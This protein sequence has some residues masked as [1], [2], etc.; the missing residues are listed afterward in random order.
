MRALFVARSLS[1]T[2]CF[3]QIVGNIPT[4]SSVVRRS[5]GWEIRESVSTDGG[6]RS[7]TLATFKQLDPDTLEHAESRASRSFDR[8]ALITAALRAGASVEAAPADGHAK[9]L[10]RELGRGASPR[11]GLCRLLRELLGETRPEHTGIAEWV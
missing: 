3:R 8:E 1:S 6:P 10:L 11:P 2:P 9:R 7:R 5:H 4:M